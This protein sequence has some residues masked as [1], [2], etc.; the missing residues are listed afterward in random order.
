MFL[1]LQIACQSD[2]QKQTSVNQFVKED[3]STL[4]PSHRATLPLFDTSP[5]A[6]CGPGVRGA[7]G[8]HPWGIKG[9]AHLWSAL[10]WHLSQPRQ[11]KNSGAECVRAGGKQSV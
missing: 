3:V 11:P 6:C 5:A 10:Q 4:P 7:F 1:D 8:K 2:A 9:V